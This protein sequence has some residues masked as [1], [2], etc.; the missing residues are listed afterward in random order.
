MLVSGGHTCSGV[1]PES[2]GFVAMEE[3]RKC[4]CVGEHS[5][6]V[7]GCIECP[8]QPTTSVGV[9]LIIMHYNRQ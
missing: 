9:V 4:I 2:Q 8:Y 3:E 5:R 6:D 1:V 7:R